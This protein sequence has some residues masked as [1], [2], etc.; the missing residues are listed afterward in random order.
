MEK[1]NKNFSENETL[2]ETTNGIKIDADLLKVLALLREAEILLCKRTESMRDDE[3]RVPGYEDQFCQ[4]ICECME[5]ASF[6]L[7]QSAID[8]V[9]DAMPNKNK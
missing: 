4:G 2:L 1:E 6:I 9:Y 8:A 3:T 5:A 7:G